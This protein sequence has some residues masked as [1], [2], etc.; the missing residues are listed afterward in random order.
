MGIFGSAKGP[1]QALK[2][3]WGE[4]GFPRRTRGSPERTRALLCLKALHEASKGFGDDCELEVANE[5]AKHLADAWAGEEGWDTDR[6]IAGVKAAATIRLDPL[7]GDDE[8][9]QQNQRNNKK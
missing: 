6:M 2:D 3:F 8:D 5:L 4:R 1:V 7:E 9:D